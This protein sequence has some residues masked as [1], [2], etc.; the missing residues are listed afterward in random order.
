[1][2]ALLQPLGLLFSQMAVLMALLMRLIGHIAY[3]LL[4]ANAGQEVGPWFCALSP[5][6]ALFGCLS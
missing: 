4:P 3:C 6:H 1:M 5:V 2:A